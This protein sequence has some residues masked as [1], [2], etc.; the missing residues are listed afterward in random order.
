MVSESTSDDRQA[1]L[2][3]APA[4]A[5]QRRLAIGVLIVSA[6][7]FVA[8]APFAKEPLRP[9][10][11]FIPIYES[12]LTVND[13]I[14]ASL[15]FVQ[16]G[17]LRWKGLLVL[18]GAYLF[19]AL[20]AV[21]HLMSFPG[22]FSAAGLL[23]SGPQSTAWLYMFWHSGFPLALI[24]Y[25][26]LGSQSFAGQ[27]VRTPIGACIT[28]VAAAACAFTLFATAGH[29]WLPAVMEGSHYTLAQ[30]IAIRA[31]WS[32]S[33]IALIVL[34]RRP[35]HS[36]LDLW[37]IVVVCAWLFDIAL[38][39]MLNAARYDLGFY[40]GRIYG[41]LAATFV[42]LVLLGEG[43]MLYA[44]LIAAHGRVRTQA[45]DLRAANKELTAVNK[46]LDAFAY[47][48]S[49]DLRAP[50][51]AMSG[52]AAM[53]TEDYADR[54][55]PAGL[56]QLEVIRGSCRRMSELID[57]LLEFSRMGHQPLRKE[58]VKLNDLVGQ[59]LD[60]LGPQ[61]DHRAIEISV[62][63]LGMVHGDPAL[64]KQ[65]FANLVGNAVKYT[66]NKPA[67]R[68][69][70]GCRSDS[71]G[72]KKT[73]FVK[74]NGSGFDMRYAEKLFHAFQ[75]LHAPSE[76]EGVGVGLAIV[77]RVIERHGGEV[78]ADATPDQGA[79]FYFTLANGPQPA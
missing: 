12:V 57:A 46:E 52:Y 48:V 43:G 26:R 25:A 17:I 56:R 6:V 27:N 38:A 64:L 3:T 59:I 50:L 65:A 69:E 53:M 8:L 2:L 77:Q 55:D 39:G 63:E 58:P 75:R 79:A 71:A 62:S 54:L 40:A 72:G 5:D 32:L 16:F 7:L 19:T 37:L 13:L 11:A 29:D 44:R 60:E 30:V 42:L 74:D 20:M 10:S 45:V 41:A 24:A 33:L 23:G 1:F 4:T 36:V 73:Y 68:I 15:L 70:I 14:T 66:R 49:H 9:V 47:S 61:T 78:W 76:F 34:W 67:A 18:A 22:L 51:R 35:S 21:A 31:V 28:A